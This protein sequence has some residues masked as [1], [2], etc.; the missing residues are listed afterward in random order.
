MESKLFDL[1][2]RLTFAGSAA[3]VLVLLLR[4][5]L[6]RLAGAQATYLCWLVVPLALAAA[7]LPVH[8]T[9]ALAVDVMPVLQAAGSGIGAATASTAMPWPDWIVR[10]WACGALASL[11]V[12]ILAQRSYVRSLG[13]LV[14]RDDI[15]IA[16]HCNAGPA[17]L[18]LW[19]PIVI[20]PSD[21][22]ERY[23]DAEQAL[24]VV[25]ER[26]HA[27]R[28]DPAANA[29]LALIRCAFWFNPLVH[30]SAARFRFDQEL[31]CDAAVMQRHGAHSQAYASAML[32]T[33]T[34]SAP[35]FATCNWQSCHPL[36]ERIMNLKSAV[37]ST[38]RRRVGHLVVALLASA[39]MLG[40]VAVRA[41]TAKSA[42]TYG[43]SVKFAEGEGNTT[44]A[45][46]VKA[47]EDMEL[48]W[49][50]PGGGWKGVF[51]VE[52]AS[53]DT[54]IVKMKVTPENGEAIAPS[55]L[56]KLGEAGAVAV[57]GKDGKPDLKIGVTVTRTAEGG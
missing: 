11:A 31:A 3:M 50:Q 15:H 39:S 18:G 23:T 8:M 1:L 10:L 32:K 20:V 48:N 51:R 21:F 28:R 52:R 29:L 49:K 19:R 56:L 12:M 34:A 47:G 22:R 9:P 16:S 26:M 25:H 2:L 7:A 17:L 30:F 44:P 37:R 43:L 55:L 40:T 33:Q 38:T 27:A 45:I 41:E 36:K 24:I 46:P 6:R 13:V 42:D 14:E 4:Q 5:P 54:V 57:S 35:A 53:A